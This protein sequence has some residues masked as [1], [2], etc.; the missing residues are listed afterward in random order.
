MRRIGMML[1][2]CGKKWRP[3]H[4]T[5]RIAEDFSR[6]SA[7]YDAHTPL[8]RHALEKLAALA[9]PYFEP[10]EGWLLDAGCGTGRFA[11]MQRRPVIQLDLASGMC[12]R[13][14][15]NGH[16]AVCADL[17]R[18][19]FADG[20][21]AGVFS[22]LALQWAAD[23]PG[24][25]AE[26]RRVMKPGCAVAFSLFARGSLLELQE[27][28]AVVDDRPHIALLPEVEPALVVER[29]TRVE[30]YPDMMSIMR[31]L[32]AIGA[33]NKDTAR[34]RGVMTPRQLARAEAHYREHFAS[35]AGLRVTWEI[36]YG[37]LR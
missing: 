16:P 17:A 15:V 34:R 25:L 19:P 5:R 18:L 36:V 26:L 10:Q 20:V 29:E 30:Y 33:R 23:L 8:Q 24:A 2:H 6:A 32:K 22:S 37:V 11:A 35:E 4:E 13:A 12:A 1:L 3:M 7:C 31:R 14:A 21:F 27:S 9:A 28:F